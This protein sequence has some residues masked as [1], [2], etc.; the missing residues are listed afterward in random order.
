MRIINK[1]IDILK[2]PKKI[3]YK[4]SSCR[5]IRLS[6]KKN[7]ELLYEIYMGKKLDLDNPITFNEKLQWL[8]LYNRKNE[9]TI[10]VDK[11]DSKKYISDKIGSEYII[12]TLGVYDNFDDIDFNILPK[13][14]VIKCTHDSGCVFIV[15]DKN[16]MDIKNIE[17]KINKSLKINYFYMSREW[18]YKHVKPRIIIEKYMIDGDH[19]ELF[20]YKFM[21]FNGKVQCTFV[22][23]DRNSG[24]GL[25][26]DSY[27]INWNKMDF[28]RNHPNA[29][30]LHSRPVNY[31]KMIEL[32][33]ILAKDIPFVRVDFYDIN[34]KI[35]FGE[36]TFFPGGGI[37]PF[38]PENYDK[39]FGD[40]IKLPNEKVIYDEEK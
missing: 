2:R 17:K 9:Y 12:P 34:G 28:T 16:K 33:E 11:C 19:D 14:F 26:I 15:K 40:L 6:E 1:F 31:D 8:K 37:T 35:Y 21:C 22:C 23:S 4:L 7:L 5:V 25:K 13:Q 18:P 30:Y 20:D 10:M 3:I 29:N 27:D 24:S 32:A 39:Y 36:I 38:N